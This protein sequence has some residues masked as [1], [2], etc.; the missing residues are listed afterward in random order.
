MN[1]K[2]LEEF[3]DA[4]EELKEL[5]EESPLIVEGK[6]DEAAL[7]K[8]GITGRIYKL[9]GRA[10]FELCEE[11]SARHE[12]VVIFL[13]NDREGRKLAK[14]ILRYFENKNIKV[15]REISKRIMQMLYANEVEALYSIALKNFGEKFA[16]INEIKRG[17][18]NGKTGY[19]YCQ[20]Y[21]TCKN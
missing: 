6:K 3:L 8:L 14:K 12:S 15:N 16:Y 20:V 21:N 9:N 2:N 11:I 7:R 19:R 1:L 5:S 18:N 10:I 4:I 17:E 13:D